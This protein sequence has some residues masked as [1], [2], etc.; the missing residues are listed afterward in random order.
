[1]NGTSG[2][3][4]LIARGDCGGPTC[5]LNEV[6]VTLVMVGARLWSL[7]NGKNSK[8]LMTQA[9]EAWLGEWFG[10]AALFTFLQS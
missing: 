2:Y 4:N 9:V 10:L 3:E 1:M 6:G 8:D 5:S 7:T